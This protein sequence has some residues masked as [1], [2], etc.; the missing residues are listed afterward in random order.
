MNPDEAQLMPCVQYRCVV[1]SRAYGLDR[2]GSDVDQRGFYL[3]PAELHWSLFGVPEQLEDRET[4][5]CY[6]EVEKFVRLALKGNPNVLEVMH[7]PLVELA[8]PIAEELLAIRTCFLSQKVHDSYL[9]YAETQF[10]RLVNSVENHGKPH[11][12]HAMHLLRLLIQGE[13]L[14]S[15]GVLAIAVQEHREFLLAV[16]D[17]LIPWGEFI[18]RK[19]LLEAQFRQAIEHSCLPEEPNTQAASNFLVRARRLAAS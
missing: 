10:R 15:E 16:K 19:G 6:W 18:E 11:W 14:V 17:G 3:P 9:G 4:D 2:G 13:R 12:K 1:G 5:E 7:S 8:T